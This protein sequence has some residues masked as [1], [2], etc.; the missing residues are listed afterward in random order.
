MAQPATGEDRAPAD[1]ASARSVPASRSARRRSR[2]SAYDLAA[3]GLLACIALIFGYVEAVFPLPIPV[4]G[5]KLGLGNVVVL[6]ALVAFGWRAGVLVMLVKVAASA[7][8]FGNPT[9]FLYSLAGGALSF[10][11]MCVGVRLRCLSVVGVSMLGGAFHMVG[12]LSV[13]ALVLAPYVALTYLPVLLV[14]GLATGLLIGYICRLVIRTVGRSSFFAQR[15]KRLARAGRRGEPAPAVPAGPRALA[16]REAG[17][18]QAPAV[19]PPAASFP[20]APAPAAPDAEPTKEMH[21]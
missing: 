20:D 2:L 8:L 16:P 4:P 11:A 10:A 14:V 17:A 15:R 5:V 12:Q 3:C 18:S 21:P 13:V 19:P 1:A 9:V 6:F 7:L